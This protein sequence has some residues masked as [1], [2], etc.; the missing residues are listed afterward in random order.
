MRTRLAN[1]YF[2]KLERLPEQEGESGDAWS[3]ESAHGS[4]ES[5]YYSDD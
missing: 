4:D 3:D 5:E 2:A 1:R